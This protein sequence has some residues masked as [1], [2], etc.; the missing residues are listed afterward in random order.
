MTETV[1][2]LRIEEYNEDLIYIKLTK[3]LK[4]LKIAIPQEKKVLIK[5]NMIAQ[6]FPFQCTITHP[7]V[8][9]AICRIL[10][11]NN[12]DL[13]IGDSSAFYQEGNTAKAFETTGLGAVAEKYKVETI[14]FEEESSSLFSN[15]EGRILKKILLPDRLKQVEY[16]INV[17]K[18]KT[19]TFF[20]LS[21]AVKNLF[22]LVPGGAKYEYHFLHGQGREVFG[23][24][25]TDLYGIVRPSLTIMDAI[26]GLEGLGP[27]AAG[28]PRQTGILG[29]AQNPFA[30]DFIFSRIIGFDPY[31]IESTS[32]GIMRGFLQDPEKIDVQGDFNQLPR[33][34]YKKPKTGKEKKPGNRG[35]LYNAVVVRPQIVPG[36]CTLCD[37][38]AEL[39]PLNAITMSQLP[40]IDLEIC[41]NCYLC[42]YKCPEGAIKL[43]GNLFNPLVKKMRKVF[44][45]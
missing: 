17:P 18:L 1:S 34:Y 20:M 39:C 41:L 6:N 2:L 5:P 3:G 12:C 29:I 27:S 26:M 9:G 23:E 32:A 25:L 38:C 19:H 31:G 45:L 43:K 8:V 4:D 30:L 40:E 42:F 11:E 16:I 22:G 44:K 21:G 14:A 28:T 36:R 24:K 35:W 37:I 13:I 10:K 7:A 33:I 15:Q